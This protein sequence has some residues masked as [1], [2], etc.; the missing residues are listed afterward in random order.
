M[1]DHSQRNNAMLHNFRCRSALIGLAAVASLSVGACSRTAADQQ[2]Q[3][4]APAVAEQPSAQQQTAIDARINELNSIEQARPAGGVVPQIPINEDSPKTKELRS[5]PRIRFGNGT[6]SGWANSSEFLQ[7]KTLIAEKEEPG[8]LKPYLH[9]IHKLYD[10][11]TGTTVVAYLFEGLGVIDKATA[12]G[13]NFDVNVI[14]AKLGLKPGGFSEQ[15][16]LPIEGQPK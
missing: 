6:V 5:K 7:P 2:V 11:E 15:P 16:G 3:S 14:V 12:E 13:A 1:S 8:K 9:T 10:S 4:L